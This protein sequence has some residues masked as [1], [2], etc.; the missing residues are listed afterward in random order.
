VKALKILA[1]IFLSFFLFISLAIFGIAFMV[2]NTALNPDFITSE[3]DRLNISKLVEEFG[4]IEAPPEMPN[5]NDVIVETIPRI[6]PLVKE[7]ASSTIYSVYDYLLGRTKNLDLASILRSTFL[8]TDFVSSLVDNIDLSSLV[9]VPLS[10]KLDEAIPVEI[11]DL[12]KYIADA[13]YE[14]EPLMK[15]QIVAAA[16]PVFGY[17]LM[18]NRT[19]DVSISLGETKEILR[20]NLRQTFFESPP[21]ELASMSR[22]TR[23]QYFNQ[24]YQEFSDTVPSIFYLDESY[25]PA[26]V[27]ED[28]ASALTEAEESLELARQ[29]IGYFQ[30]GYLLLI[31]FMVL[32]ILGIVLIIRRVK[33]VTRLLGILLLICGAI[34]YIGI[35]VVQYYINGRITFPDMP[36][37]LETWLIQLINNVLSPLA[38]FS[39]GILIC[40]A[41]LVVVSFVYRRGQD[42]LMP[43]EVD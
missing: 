1:L 6:E 19:L 28:I 40:G 31:V 4:D 35:W 2:Q 16:D 30:L 43:T 23:E 34:E 20:E 14:A 22:S 26:D 33:G 17:I 5:L 3:L 25:I 15:E 10:Q 24:F 39:L 42:Q 9:G 36:L 12:D 13:L 37:Y 38:M 32:I 7:K 11:A 21:P 29:Y 41:I 27:P 18:E 8:S